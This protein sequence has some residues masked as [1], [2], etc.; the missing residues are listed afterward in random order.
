MKKIKIAGAFIFILS[1]LLIGLF[2]YE[3]KLKERHD[4]LLEI[5]NEQK[6]FTQEISK[7]IFYIYKHPNSSNEVIEKLIKEFLKSRHN[8]EGGLENNPQIRELWNKFYLHVQHFRDKINTNSPYYNMLIE[9]DVKDI[10]NTN[11]ELILLSTA[12]IANSQKKHQKQHNMLKKIQYI[13]FFL[14]IFFLLY[15]F[16]QLKGTIAFIQ[17]FLHTSKEIISK[18]S[19]TNLE[20]ILV[21]KKNTDVL[22]AQES[23]NALVATINESIQSATD[24][25]EHTYKSLEIVQHH[26]DTLVELIYT[27]RQESR[28]KELRQKED[29]IIQSFEELSI[30]VK[31]LQSLKNSLQSLIISSKLNNS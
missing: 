24:S 8:K 1:L 22:Q 2:S 16:T 4:T 5:M 12:Y 7:N 19:I 13:L 21:D 18:S 10:Y 31:N 27:M 23:F 11:L 28:D 26:I 9:K 14:L 20:P 17:K 6:N 15:L 3:S 29:A 30:S 25:M